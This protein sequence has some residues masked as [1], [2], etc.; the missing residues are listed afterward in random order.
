[1]YHPLAAELTPRKQFLKT[2]F[3]LL[4]LIPQYF[5]SSTYLYSLYLYTHPLSEILNC[6]KM[7]LFRKIRRYKIFRFT[8]SESKKWTILRGIKRNLIFIY[9]KAG[10]GNKCSLSLIELCPW[11]YSLIYLSFALWKAWIKSFFNVIIVGCQ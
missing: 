1:M 2:T 5:Y 4:Y 8:F 9:C 6:R 10:K 11:R 3:K 7:P